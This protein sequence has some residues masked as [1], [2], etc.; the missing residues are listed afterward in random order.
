MKRARAAGKAERCV[1]TVQTACNPPV[2]PLMSSGLSMLRPIQTRISDCTE[3]SVGSHK[4][5]LHLLKCLV[6]DGPNVPV[7]YAQPSCPQGANEICCSWPNCD[8]NNACASCTAAFLVSRCNI[9]HIITGACCASPFTCTPE[10]I[11]ADRISSF[12][13]LLFT[14]LSSTLTAK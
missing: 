11:A 4:Y 5:P 10:T 7:A 12:L 13:S 2:S 1:M 3:Y 14:L 8:R 6:P 9:A